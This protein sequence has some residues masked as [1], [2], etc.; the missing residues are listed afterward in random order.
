MLRKGKIG[1]ILCLDIMQGI[2]KDELKNRASFEWPINEER[3]RESTLVHGINLA[4]NIRLRDVH[5]DDICRVYCLG[6]I[7]R[8]SLEN[9]IF[10]R[11]RNDKGEIRDK[12]ANVREVIIKTLKD[13][14]LALH[15]I[16]LGDIHHKFHHAI[17]DVKDSGAGGSA[18]DSALRCSGHRD[19]AGDRFNTFRPELDKFICQ[20]ADARKRIG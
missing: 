4:G 7:I 9:V 14:K 3:Y 10:N 19:L 5:K 12:S 20:R 13:I 1:R 11:V 17:F 18:S 16:D 2:V 15:F 6:V 8:S